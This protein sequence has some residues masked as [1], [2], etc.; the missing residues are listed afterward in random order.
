MLT[1]GVEVEQIVEN[2]KTGSAQ[3]VERDA[4]ESANK[5]LDRQVVG[6]D[7]GQK[8]QQIFCPV[9]AAEGV[10]PYTKRRAE[11]FLRF[12]D[13]AFERGDGSGL[14]STR[15]VADNV[16][17]LSTAPNNHVSGGVPH[18]F[19]AG[20]G[21]ALCQKC[22]LI[23]AFEIYLAVT[24]VNFVEQT[25]I[26]RNRFGKFAVGGSCEDNTSPAGLFP[27]KKIENLLPV[28]ETSRV[29]GDPSCEMAFEPSAPRQQPDRKQKQGDGA[30]FEEEKNALPDD[31]AA[32][33]SAVKID[34]QYRG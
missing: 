25:E 4:G 19:K 3:A 13:R 34:A 17:C 26:A 24:C 32:D 7:K 15:L 33:Q 28:G 29:E 8:K 9:V 11:R 27:L 18:I 20:L 1:V 21:E 22:R 5:W 6:Q 16:G 12:R 2:V 14:L 30:G 31:V 23:R 10:N